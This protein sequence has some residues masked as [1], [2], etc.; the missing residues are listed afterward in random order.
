MDPAG[1]GGTMCAGKTQRG[2]GRKAG[3]EQDLSIPGEVQGQRGFGSWSQGGPESP[4]L[5]RVRAREV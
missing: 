2:L 3:P 5:S 4:E 1:A